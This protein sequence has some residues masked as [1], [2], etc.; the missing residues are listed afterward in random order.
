MPLLS[1]KY[2]NLYE[3]MKAYF[4]KYANIKLDVSD[5]KANEDAV[6][7]LEIIIGRFEDFFMSLDDNDTEE[8]GDYLKNKGTSI[9]E[10]RDKAI[11][12]CGSNIVATLMFYTNLLNEYSKFIVTLNKD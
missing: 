3:L 7:D 11:I 9:D 5:K 6:I 12:I 1:E 10:I 2:L 4:K 8:F